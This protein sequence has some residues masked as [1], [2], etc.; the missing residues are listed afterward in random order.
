L[1][2]PSLLIPRRSG[3]RLRSRSR[4]TNSRIKLS[5]IAALLELPGDKKLNLGAD[6]K[7]RV[8]RR[9]FHCRDKIEC[10][11]KSQ[12]LEELMP[13][14]ATPLVLRDEHISEAL[15]LVNGNFDF[16]QNIFRRPSSA[17]PLLAV[18]LGSG[19]RKVAKDELGTRGILRKVKIVTG[20]Q[21]AT[22]LLRLRHSARN[23]ANISIGG[24]LSRDCAP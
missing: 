14:R 13:F 2:V 3:L 4:V 1:T 22:G 7:V 18:P 5:K 9:S 20:T 15:S 10:N 11:L 24:S 19:T 12:K 17:S 8:S 6:F 16:F 23:Q 21:L